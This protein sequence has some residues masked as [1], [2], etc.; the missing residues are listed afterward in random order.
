VVSGVGEVTAVTSVCG[1]ASEVVGAVLAM[2]AG[3]GGQRRRLL[4]ANHGGRVQLKCT[5]S[6][7]G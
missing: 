3:G 5:R 7:M 6:S 4:R 1:L 2:S